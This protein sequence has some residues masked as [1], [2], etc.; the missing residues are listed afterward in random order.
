[1]NGDAAAAGDVA[2][3]FVA[4]NWIA[5]LRAIHQQIV[6]ALDDE[7]RFAEAQH[8]LDGFDQRRLGVRCFGSATLFRLAQDFA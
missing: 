2:D 3:D 8:A 5:T 7:R 6:V 4:G 1:M